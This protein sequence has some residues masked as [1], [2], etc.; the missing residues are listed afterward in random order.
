MKTDKPL[1]YLD[2]INSNH[3]LFKQKF[4]IKMFITCIAL[5]FPSLINQITLWTRSVATG[6][7]RL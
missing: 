2:K 1:I 3:A 6:F 7:A 5:S 4:G